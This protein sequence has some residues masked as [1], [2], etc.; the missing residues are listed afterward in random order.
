MPELPEV[1]TLRRQLARTIK[2]KTIQAL[3]FI[4]A[5]LGP[6]PDLKGRGVRDVRRRGKFLEIALDDGSA[7]KLHLRMTGRLFRRCV[8]EGAEMPAHTRFRLI[9]EGCEILGVDPRRFATLTLEHSSRAGKPPPD[10]L[11]NQ[12]PQAWHRA[13]RRRQL[14][15]KTFLL[16]QS[17]FPGMGNIYACE[18]L[19]AA[20]VDPRRPASALAGKEWEKVGCEAKRILDLAVR[21]RG[22]SMSDWRDLRGQAGRFQHRLRVYGRKGMPCLRCG[23]CIERIVLG[24]RGT[25]FCA[26]CQK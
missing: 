24:G 13:A 5:K 6:A 26:G 22:T 2:G 8:V 17:V 11:E 19:H 23:S 1:E 21:C 10:L 4:D 3:V 16:D 14:A 12:D 15:V 25:W 7:L 9:F 18:I 20:A